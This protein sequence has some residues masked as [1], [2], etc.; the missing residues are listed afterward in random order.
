MIGSGRGT[1]RTL[2]YRAHVSQPTFEY[3]IQRV[4]P[5]ALEL[6]LPPEPGVFSQAVS[7]DSLGRIAADAD[8]LVLVALAV[9]AEGGRIIGQLTAH[10]VGFPDDRPSDLFIDELAVS[11]SW[12]RR[13]VGSSLLN[14]LNSHTGGRELGNVRLVAA[15]DNAA[16]SALY[17][18]HGSGPSPALLYTFRRGAVIGSTAEDAA[19]RQIPTA[20]TLDLHPGE[21]AA[22]SGPKQAPELRRPPLERVE[23]YQ[24]LGLLGEGGSAQVRRVRDLELNRVVAMKIIHPERSSSSLARARFIEEIQ[25][26]AQLQHPGILPL[27]DAGRLPDGR[28]WF[29]MKEVRGKTLGATIRQVH[30]AAGPGMPVAPAGLRWLVELLHKASLAVIYAHEHGVLH[31]DLKPANI[32]I[33]DLGEVWVMDWGLSKAPEGGDGDH[34]DDGLVSLDRERVGTVAGRVLGTPAYMAPE[35]AA[36]KSAM[37]DIRTDVYALGAILYEILAGRSPYPG[38]NALDVVR[39]VLAGPP[40]PPSDRAAPGTELP[41]ALVDVCA[42]AMARQPEDRFA[43]VRQFAG[44]IDAW[45]RGWQLQSRTFPAGRVF[46]RE[47]EAG[48]KAWIIQS[49][50]CRVFRTVDGRDLELG[51]LGPGDVCGETAAMT[52]DVRIASVQALDEVRVTEVERSALA[53][54]LRLETPLGAFVLALARRFREAEL[55]RR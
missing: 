1:R 20:P 6:P 35:Q 46:A 54:A 27:Y 12:R 47:G 36:G 31:R 55:G 26:T 9:T 25:I 45:L 2:G 22:A 41:A 37:L 32:M 28:V 24:D 11:P 16:A 52:G 15:P 50:R 49:G 43:S 7:P 53:E 51:E 33:A 10:W 38:T 30:A 14:A 4:M 34:G 42:R 44:A 3:R 17:A 29:T 13:G 5:P 18:R 39:Q 40:P 19:R 23:R 21:P 8:R 48:T